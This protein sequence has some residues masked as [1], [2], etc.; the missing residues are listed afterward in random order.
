MT[1]ARAARDYQGTIWRS[2]SRRRRPVFVEDLIEAR[3]HITTGGKLDAHK[4]N[5]IAAKHDITYEE[6]S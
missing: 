6:P 3:P 2:R 1:R 5:P 4:L